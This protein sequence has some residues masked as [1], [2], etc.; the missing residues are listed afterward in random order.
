MLFSC[1][2]YTGFQQKIIIQNKP[3]C[4]GAFKTFDVYADGTDNKVD[5]LQPKRK[6]K[7]RIF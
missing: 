4:A 6:V 5:T 7:H 1:L 3:T 2:R